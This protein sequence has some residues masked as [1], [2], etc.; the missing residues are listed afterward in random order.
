MSK[1]WM[2][3]GMA[4]MAAGLAGASP[5]GAQSAPQPTSD[6]RILGKPDA[7]ITIFEYASLTCPHCAEFDRETLPKLK[8][9][10]LDTGKA[11]LIFRD[12]PLDASALKAAMLARCAPPD[13]F[14]GFIDVLFRG[15]QSWAVSRDLDGSLGKLAKLGGLSDETFAACM[16]NDELQ[17]KIVAE[18]YQA[19][20]EYGVDST[21]TFFINGVKFVGA[22]PFPEFDKAL[23]QAAS[24]S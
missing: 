15:Q 19:E 8:E 21:P 17:K 2:A 13:Q 10:W 24:K 6:D 9:A 16:K 1:I 4:L 18:R 11:R 23:A 3:L 7:P 20:K 5:A 12:F 14:Y 22:Q